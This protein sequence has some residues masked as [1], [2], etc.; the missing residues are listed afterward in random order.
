MYGNLATRGPLPAVGD[1]RH[2]RLTP[3]LT[4][5]GLI[6]RSS[7][8]PSQSVIF[9]DALLLCLD[10]ELGDPKPHFVYLDEIFDM[11]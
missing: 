8:L 2:N 1:A 7:D 6:V 5:I 4:A 3:K 10:F 11:V 9:R